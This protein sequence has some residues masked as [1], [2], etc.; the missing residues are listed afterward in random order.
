[1]SLP[2]ENDADS[3]PSR[4]SPLRNSQPIESE[5]DSTLPLAEKLH[6]SLNDKPEL[7]AETMGRGRGS[8]STLS[9]IGNYEILYE[10]ARGGMGVIY[11]AIDRQLDRVVALKLIKSGELADDNEVQRF[12]L[13][14]RAAAQ[15]D[16]PGI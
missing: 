5:G 8:G 10:I 6:D 1:M 2:L 15:L 13:E 14:A 3:R 4:T 16:H 9:P 7:Q 12:Q 11:K